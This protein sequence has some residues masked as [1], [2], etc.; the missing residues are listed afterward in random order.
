MQFN[1]ITLVLL[2]LV[3][4]GFSVGASDFLRK[5]SNNNVAE[6]F[7]E[8]VDRQFHR[9]L[10]H[11]NF[12][13]IT[14]GSAVGEVTETCSNHGVC[15]SNGHCYCSLKYATYPD[16]SDTECNYHRKSR[17]IAFCWH[18]FFG[19]E[20]G[21]GEWYLGNKDYATFEVVLFFPA[22]IGFIIVFGCFGCCVD[23]AQE[24]KGN[25]AETTKCCGCIGAVL[26][27]CS[28]IAMFGFWGYELWAI[29]TYH[30]TD[31]NGVDTW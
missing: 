14:P 11:S 7:E 25:E 26:G 29:A 31:G 27:V 30:R 22:L 20:A 19:L 18:L 24:K 13:C 15:Q 21:A 28:V 23:M 12:T 1:V 16:D 2:L 5:S 6:T 17:F 4:I 8:F 9:T 3:N 10:S